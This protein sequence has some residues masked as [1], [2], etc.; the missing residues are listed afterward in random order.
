MSQQ[1]E[2]WNKIYSKKQDHEVSWYQENPATSVNL[3]EKYY[4][5]KS[6]AIIDIGGGNAEFSRTLCQ[7]G[8][9]SLTV[10][11][12]SEEA[13]ERSRAKIR[14][15]KGIT[16]FIVTD[17]LNFKPHTSYNIWHDR[18]VFHFLTNKTDIEKYIR[19]ASKHIKQNGYLILSTFSLSGP[20]KCSG[21]TVSKYSA[22]HLA[23]L[24]KEHFNFIEAFEETHQT[25]MGS[26]QNF[27]WCVMKKN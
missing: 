14:K 9:K 26:T 16:D 8:F 18:A 21:L 10:L 7:K 19:L 24:F 11:D 23:E 3:I 12:I 17:I 13:I 27:V 25:P 20:D 4:Q 15:C 1:K 6:E 5:N 22:S 2:H